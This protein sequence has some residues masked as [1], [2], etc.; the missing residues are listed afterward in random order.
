MRFSGLRWSFRPT[1][2]TNHGGV[3]AAQVTIDSGHDL[4]VYEN[5]ARGPVL[6]AIDQ[7]LVVEITYIQLANFS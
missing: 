1:G 2:A 6:S 4:P 5:L 7:L 3:G